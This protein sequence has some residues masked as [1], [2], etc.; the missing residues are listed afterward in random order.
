MKTTTMKTNKIL[1]I[2]FMLCMV[3]AGY[4]QEEQLFSIPLS[5]PSKPGKLILQQIAGSITVKAYDG[6]EVIVRA[7]YGDKRINTDNSKNGLR[8]IAKASVSISAEEFDNV[9]RIHNEIPNRKVDFDI[10]VPKNFDLRLKTINQGEINVTGVK[11]DLELSN[12]NGGIQGRNL[13]GAVA[14]DT[15]NGNIIMDF[16][17]INPEVGMAFSSYNG[18]IDITLPKN[19]KATVKIKADQGEVLTDFDIAI[20]KQTPQ[21]TKESSSKGYRVKVEQWVNGTING[22]GPELLFKSYWSDVVIRSK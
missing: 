6:K 18:K 9:I 22:G 2:V 20:D 4:G 12:T 13:N 14:A 15:T 1:S 10:Q 3:L 11:G 21:V 7:S 16:D 19:V 5:E 8:R 17:G